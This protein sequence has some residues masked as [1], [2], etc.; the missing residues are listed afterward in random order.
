M[1]IETQFEN[2]IKALNIPEFN[3]AFDV[4][5]ESPALFTEQVVKANG[6]A[7]KAHILYQWAKDEVDQKMRR[8]A[9]SNY[10]MTQCCMASLNSIG[11]KRPL[12]SQERHH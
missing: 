5:A 10:A 2:E 4:V 1:L 8:N 12:P 7:E 3:T 9:R 11:R 6:S